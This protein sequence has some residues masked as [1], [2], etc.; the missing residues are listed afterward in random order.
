MLHD[1]MTEL[2]QGRAA[3]V[4]ASFLGGDDRDVEAPIQTVDEQPGAPVRHRH[5]PAGLGNRAVLVD[6]LQQFNLAWANG[7]VSVEI[8][9]QRQLRHSLELIRSPS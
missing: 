2:G 7:A 6:H 4:L 9:T 1:G 8:D 5:L 3:A